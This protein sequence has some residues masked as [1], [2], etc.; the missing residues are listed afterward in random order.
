MCWGVEGDK[1]ERERWC[2]RVGVFMCMNWTHPSVSSTACLTFT[3]QGVLLVPFPGCLEATEWDRLTAPDVYE[4][5]CMLFACRCWDWSRRDPT[6]AGSFTYQPRVEVTP[7]WKPWGVATHE[8]PMWTL[9]TTS[10]GSFQVIMQLMTICCFMCMCVCMHACMC[11][12]EEYSTMF[13][14]GGYLIQEQNA[15]KC[16]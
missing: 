14:Q 12:C 11:V 13:W 1:R 4:S 16:I 10:A 7:C 15:I 2:E 6:Y 9:C 5:M 3:Q 8:L